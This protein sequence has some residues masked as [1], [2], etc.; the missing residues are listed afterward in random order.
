[1]NFNLFDNNL[2]LKSPNSYIKIFM[3]IIIILF[4][5]ILTFILVLNDF[6]KRIPYSTVETTYINSNINA[7]VNKVNL[8]NFKNPSFSFATLASQ[9][10]EYGCFFLEYLNNKEITI[11]NYGLFIMLKTYVEIENLT[12]VIHTKS[13]IFINYM[14]FDTLNQNLN[15]ENK[16]KFNIKDNTNF[17]NFIEYDYVTN[18][19]LVNCNIYYINLNKNS[20]LK[21]I[22]NT[23]KNNQSINLLKKNILISIENFKNNIKKL[24]PKRINSFKNY[25]SEIDDMVITQVY[26]RI[27]NKTINTHNIYNNSFNNINK[28]YLN[29]N[30]EYPY[31]PKLL[32]NLEGNNL[33]YLNTNN[34][35]LQLNE[36]DMFFANSCINHYTLCEIN[37]FN[38]E[39]KPYLYFDNYNTFDFLWT[40]NSY[41][42]VENL[43]NTNK[44]NIK[45]NFKYVINS[46]HLKKYDSK[47]RF[48]LLYNSYE[49]I[50]LNLGKFNKNLF[51]YLESE[52][53]KFNNI[54]LKNS[55][56]MTLIKKSFLQ[57]CSAQLV[58]NLK[59]SYN[60][61]F[62]YLIKNY[63]GLKYVFPIYII[64]FLFFMLIFKYILGL[65][66]D[67]YQYIDCVNLY[68]KNLQ[69]KDYLATIN[70]NINPD[71]L[72]KKAKK[73]NVDDIISINSYNNNLGIKNKLSSY[74]KFN[75][76]TF[77]NKKIGESNLNCA[78]TNDNLKSEL[79][80]NVNKNNLLLSFNQFKD[81]NIITDSSNTLNITQSNLNFYKFRNTNINKFRNSDIS[82]YNKLN[83]CYYSNK[84][85]DS[86]NNISNTNKNEYLKKFYN[87]KNSK[88][89][90][91]NKDSNYLNN[92]SL[93][94]NL[95]DYSIQTIYKRSNKKKILKNTF[96]KKYNKNS[97]S[98]NY[99]SNVTIDSKNFLN[100]NIK[101]LNNKDTTIIHNNH[102]NFSKYIIQL[103]NYQ[104]FRK[105]KSYEKVNKI[106]IYNNIAI[107]NFFNNTSSYDKDTTKSLFMNYNCTNKKQNY[108]SKLLYY[109]N[110]FDNS[111]CTNKYNLI[112]NSILKDKSCNTDSYSNL[113]NNTKSCN[114]ELYI[115]KL[116][117]TIKLNS[118]FRDSSK[119]NIKETSV[120]DKNINTNKT[121]KKTICS[122]VNYNTNNIQD[123]KSKVDNSDI[124]IYKLL[125]EL[126]SFKQL[127]YIEYKPIDLIMFIFCNF[128]K[129]K[130]KKEL[131]YKC[132]SRLEFYFSQQYYISLC[133]SHEKNIHDILNENSFFKT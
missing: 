47:S 130:S 40:T 9:D 12:Y 100:K 125:N 60:N 64:I 45:D 91:V 3:S 5:F 129:N 109:N 88:Q 98:K 79:L 68:L 57:T 71:N 62:N 7:F 44:F 18:S 113:K 95:L 35:N 4:S 76:N 25:Y 123:I 86:S 108:N 83:S 63:H 116:A 27:F 90:I 128:N 41:K 114:K 16:I 96:T 121:Y 84:I 67:N 112:S 106:N 92:I 52:S 89:F 131:F 99:Y 78:N 50:K 102:T 22:Y 29:K 37:S 51:L 74:S 115:K 103:P 1:M 23:I 42:Y 111:K 119:F 124:K 72:L 94:E 93:N 59:F 133:S 33:N 70:T 58:V 81:T 54:N 65:F 26:Q 105:S 80:K 77:I 120:I 28:N 97:L 118:N 38:I 69:T 48:T 13:N 66:Y 85:E 19:D 122:S 126:P 14:Y 32:I 53:L 49:R 34:N 117:S 127:G 20:Y 15:K 82:S 132:K 73:S 107:D 55:Y 11:D 31:I 17:N 24:S 43:F 87:Y 75:N 110:V 8:D 6:S 2:K 30:I 56:Q 21:E 39:F 61:N 104:N 46:K 10:K 101:S 36:N